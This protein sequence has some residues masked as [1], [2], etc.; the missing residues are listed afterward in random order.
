M[1][2]RRPIDHGAAGD[3]LSSET[4]KTATMMTSTPIATP[5]P[6]STAEQPSTRKEPPPE[7]LSD[8]HRRIWVIGSFWLIVLLL[9]LPIWWKTT[10]IHRANLPLKEMLDW[11][12]GKVRIMMEDMP[13]LKLGTWESL[14]RILLLYV[15]M[16]SCLS[17][18]HLDTSQLA[19]GAG[20]SEPPPSDPA[21]PR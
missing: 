5:L 12:D 1:S 4:Q 10:T 8:V 18:A 13:R 20:G 19:P 11:A 21:R 9:G 3:T 6:P 17:P 7:K 14:T 2:A 15:G 16:S